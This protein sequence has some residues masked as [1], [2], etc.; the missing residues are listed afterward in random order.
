YLY[1]IEVLAYGDKISK[2]KDAIFPVPIAA[3]LIPQIGKFDKDGYSSE[4]RKIIAESRKILELAELPISATCVRVPCQIGHCEAVNIE[5]PQSVD[6]SKVKKTLKTAGL[7]VMDDEHYPMPVN[8]EN[9]DSVYVGRIR[10][11]YAF[12][13]G[14]VLWLGTDNLRKGAATNAVQIAELLRQEKNASN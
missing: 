4:E 7:V 8:I 3:N 12:D 9:T 13:N 5:F 2:D 14:I 6:I 1:E 10:K 11:D